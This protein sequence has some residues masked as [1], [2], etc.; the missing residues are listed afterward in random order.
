MNQ[1]EAIKKHET[2][3]KQIN[4]ICNFLFTWVYTHLHQVV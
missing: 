3:R 4:E 1:E 2:I